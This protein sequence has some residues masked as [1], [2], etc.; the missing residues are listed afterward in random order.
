MELV[1]FSAHPKS[2]HRFALETLL[3]NIV[4]PVSSHQVAL[5]SIKEE[6]ESLEVAARRL[7]DAFPTPAPEVIGPII[8]HATRLHGMIRWACS[9]SYWT[10]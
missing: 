4:G 10:W 5:T 1:G 9:C 2:I 3:A 7:L 6:V 8:Q